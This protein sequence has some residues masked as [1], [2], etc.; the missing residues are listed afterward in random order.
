MCI[1]LLLCAWLTASH[2]FAVCVLCVL[3]VCITLSLVVVVR[4]F[5][6]VSQVLKEGEGTKEEERER[7]E[8]ICCRFPAATVSRRGQVRVSFSVKLLL[9]T[10]SSQPSVV[11]HQQQQ[12]QPPVAHL[13]LRHL[14]FFKTKK[15]RKKERKSYRKRK[16][17]GRVTRCEIKL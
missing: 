9:A 17:R 7:N 10:P 8:I 6:L 14:S 1:L 15:E 5:R 16:E 3:C 12:Q 2:D 13:L 4:P 11:W